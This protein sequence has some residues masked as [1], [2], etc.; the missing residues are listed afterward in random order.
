MH[1]KFYQINQY[2][3]AEELRVVDEKATQL[4]VMTKDAAVKL[5]EDQGLDLIL[6]APNALPP[7]AKIINFAKFKY[8]Q[9]QKDSSSKKTSKNVEIKEIRLTPFIG[10]SDFEYRMKKGREY[11]E[12]GNKV[13]LNVKFVGRQITHKE[14]GDRVMKNAVDELSDLSTIERGPQFQGKILIAQLQPKKR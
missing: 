13:R 2:I 12:A 1:K 14:F 3:R 7:V 9:Q 6:V 10:E 5:A 4:G 8:Q 11:L